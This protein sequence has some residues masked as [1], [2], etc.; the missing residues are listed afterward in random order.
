[1]AH[2]QI[3]RVGF[4]VNGSIDEVIELSRIIRSLEHRFPG[5]K[6]DY[7]KAADDSFMLDLRKDLSLRD[8]LVKPLE[9]QLI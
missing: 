2:P 4:S 8:E 3:S 1:V 9:R 7:F 6:V 5:L